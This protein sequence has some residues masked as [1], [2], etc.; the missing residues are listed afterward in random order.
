MKNSFGLLAVICMMMFALLTYGVNFSSAQDTENVTQETNST[1][2]ANTNVTEVK[3]VP[4]P[5][6]STSFVFPSSNNQKFEVAK[7]I[8]VV[9]ALKNNGENI[10]NVSTIGAS[11]L[12]KNMVI[13]EKKIKLQ[14]WDTAGQERF[15]SLTPMYYRDAKA[16]LL[17]YDITSAASFTKVKEWVNELR[18]G[19]PYDILLVVVGNKLDKAEAEEFFTALQQHLIQK[20]E[21]KCQKDPKIRSLPP[22]MRKMAQDLAVGIAQAPELKTLMIAQADKNHDGEISWQEFTDYMKAYHKN[23]QTQK[24][25]H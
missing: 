15:K 3:L 1:E 20:I 18:V 6:A 14:I 10:F 4:H 25:S 22:D 7:S 23:V 8:T 5:D 9:V 11:F 2:A 21:K 19:V 16:A 24:K 12:M 13:D 17:V